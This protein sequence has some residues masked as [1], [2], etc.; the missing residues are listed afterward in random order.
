MLAATGIAVAAGSS[1]TVDSTIADRDGD[2]RLESAPGDDYLR[3]DEL[4]TRT[5]TRPGLGLLTSGS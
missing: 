5:G 1:S 4:G 2:N 3:R